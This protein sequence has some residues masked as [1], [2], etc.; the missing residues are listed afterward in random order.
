ML[1]DT[2]LF[3]T[4]TVLLALLLTVSVARAADAPPSG[5]PGASPATPAIA[6]PAPPAT[7]APATTPS[8]VGGIRNKISADDLLSAESILE[9]HRATHGED[10]QWLVGYA[11]LGRGAL[12]VGE[13][14]KAKRY[15]DA[16]YADCAKRVAGG[17]DLHV[18]TDLR[19]ALGAAIEVEAQLLERKSGAKRAA[20]YVRAELARWNGPAGFR[21]RL[22]KRIDLMTLEGS[23][24][25]E[26]TVEDHL[27]DPPPSLASLKG[28][29]VVIYVWDKG[30]GDCRAQATA[31]NKAHDRFAKE[32]VEFV[33]LT[34]YYDKGDEL[35]T[36]KTRADSSWKASHPDMGTVPVVISTASMERYGGSSTPTFIFLDRKG[37]V[38]RYTPTRLTEDELTR[39]VSALLD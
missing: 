6:T 31:L 28:K 17:A 16:V 29:P 27:G 36:E 38:W 13:P 18:D 8:P 5:A 37:V 12:L 2:P 3:R 26:L 30:C 1:L 33:A 7:P 23:P 35:R 34:R 24:A 15:A 10:G 32:G 9:V 39:T 11:W 20:D 25:P 22:G 21:A 19:Y 14:G 4:P